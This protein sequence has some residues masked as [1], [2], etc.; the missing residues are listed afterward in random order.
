MTG[1]VGTAPG[2]SLDLHIT[3]SVPLALGNARLASRGAALDGVLSVDIAVSGT[4][5]SPQF[6]GRVTSEG[7]GFVDPG[8]GIVLKGLRLA[9]T[10]SGKSLQ[11]ETLQ[12]ASGTGSVA[13][14]GSIGL[15]P[16]EG[17]PVDLTLQIRQARYVDG[18][19]ARKRGNARISRR[20]HDLGD[21]TL[22]GQPRVIVFHIKE[23]REH[24]H[25]VWSRIISAELKA[26]P[27]SHDR[28]SL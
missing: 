8:T 2:A 3:G 24:C 12:A 27:I 6:S 5:A 11:I 1:T 4:A 9:A 17:F 18:T 10:V 28:K 7:G 13:A 25:V 21:V 22:G 26:I 19:R 20:A 16:N 23:R 14:T 15:D